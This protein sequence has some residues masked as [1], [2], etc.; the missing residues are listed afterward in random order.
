[1][2]L[3]DTFGA[4]RERQ[5]RLLWL[6][7]AT[8]TIGDGL[9]PVALAF[10]VIESL[11]GT[12]TQLGLVLAA[13]TLPLVAFVLIGGVWADRLPRQLVMLV[14]DLIR[15]VVQATLAILFLTGAAELWHLVTLIA[16]YGSAEAFFQPAA[17]GVV[18]ATVS[19]QRLQQ[20]NAMLGLTRS[21]AFVIGPAIAGAVVA[22]ANPGFVFAVDAA[23]FA[24]SATSLA[25]LRVPRRVRERARESFLAEL[26]GG[27]RELVSRTWL[28][29]II[30]WATTILFAV[31]APFQTLGPVIAKQSLGGA[32]AWGTIAA[33]FGLGMVA[34]GITALRLRP[35]RPMLA[36]SLA[37]FLAVPGPALLAM[38]APVLA[39]AAAQAA[40]G[41]AIGFFVA[42]WQT[43]LQQHVP[44]E[45][46]SRV[47]AWDWMGS[48]AFM[49]LGFVLAG[50]V[51]DQIGISTT[52]WIGVVWCALSTAVVVAVPG[53]R[54]V[55]RIDAPQEVPS[56]PI[57]DPVVVA[58]KPEP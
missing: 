40:A 56:G 5:F 10:A 25:L 35:S 53:V 1:M 22:V 28:W 39:I 44:E 20:A 17:T 30:V 29:V 34:G 12:A 23:T 50:P 32:A 47:S 55:R 48:F 11:D 46:L 19:P 26:A 49:P 54:N 9:L 3:S 16:V 42:L 41:V 43:T 58:G 38:R 24:V 15:C 36:C 37:F 6:G 27:W 45:A 2:A 14:S 57:P 31:F 52:L 51:S 4:L 18:P 13:H 21:G 8:S 33:A 7:Q